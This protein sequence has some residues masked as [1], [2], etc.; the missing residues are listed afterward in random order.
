MLA[1]RTV[2]ALLAE[3]EHIEIDFPSLGSR[4]DQDPEPDAPVADEQEEDDF[5]WL[6]MAFADEDEPDVTELARDEDDDTDVEHP[7]PEDI[8]AIASALDDGS[9]HD[10]PPT[11][12]RAADENA[13]EVQP[14]AAEAQPTA[15]DVQPTTATDA[16]LRPPA[17]SNS[18]DEPIDEHWTAA[19]LAAD[20]SAVIA[21]APE[22][23]IV[24]AFE[25]DDIDPLDPLDLDLDEVLDLDDVVSQ[26]SVDSLEELTLTDGAD[27][28]DVAE[29]ASATTA[30][31]T[32]ASS[33]SEEAPSGH[34]ARD[35][36]QSAGRR[37]SAGGAPEEDAPVESPPTLGKGAPIADRSEPGE[38]DEPVERDASEPD[39]NAAAEDPGPPRRS[40]L[41]EELLGTFSQLYGKR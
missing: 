36:D 31:D 19:D 32:A 35:L 28:P 10:A 3:H 29:P 24:S 15:T 23:E 22:V 18:L 4:H 27:Q 38:P 2:G 21:D 12:R 9:S 7:S 1:R 11:E 6:A 33:P 8:E 5:S 16:Q 26:L 40:G 41:R 30:P 25:A 39:E 14:T 13:A 20:L 34:E 17:S 37:S